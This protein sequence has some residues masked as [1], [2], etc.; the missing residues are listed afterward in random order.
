MSLNHNNVS[1]LPIPPPGTNSLATIGTVIPFLMINATMGAVEFAM[2][3]A[4][5]F[6][7][8][9]ASRRKPLFILNVTALVMGIASAV[10][11]IICEEVS[12]FVYHLLFFL[13]KS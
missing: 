12:A 11:Q 13:T 2:L 10:I 6:F 8:T 9:V 3:L 1:S 5:F 4:L 7:P